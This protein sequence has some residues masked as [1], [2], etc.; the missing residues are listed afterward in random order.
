M[1]IAISR[2]FG[3]GLVT[4]SPTTPDAAPSKPAETGIPTRK[5]LPAH[6]GGLTTSPTLVASWDGY[7]TNY[8]YDP[9]DT[10]PF[11][12]NP[13]NPQAVI[14]PEQF[15]CEYPE[16]SGAALDNLEL[17]ATQTIDVEIPLDELTLTQ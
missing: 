8:V 16:I 11:A 2:H 1:T 17:P 3:T 10:Q 12:A 6:I 9:T 4:T 15:V 5:Y 14:Y 13:S 7:F